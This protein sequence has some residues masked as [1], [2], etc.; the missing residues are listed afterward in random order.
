MQKIGFGGGCHWCT[1][2]VFECLDGVDEVLQGWISS[3]EESKGAFSEAVL[4]RYDPFV[5][6]LEILVE[7]H[8]LTHNSSSN[9]SMRDKYR[10]AI[11]TFNEEQLQEAKD[12]LAKKA[13]LFHKP[14]VTEVL[15]LEEFKLN[16]QKYLHYYKK[17]PSRA[18]CRTYIEPKLKMIVKEYSK[19]CHF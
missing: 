6:P 1:E 13:N 2:A 12:I 5:I 7:I 18:F 14:I 11:Y 17:D 4:L 19:Y 8:L 10:S 3:S 15:P 9:H 16:Q